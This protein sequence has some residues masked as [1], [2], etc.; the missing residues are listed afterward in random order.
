MNAYDVLN[1]SEDLSK[2]TDEKLG[3]QLDCIIKSR[4]ESVIFEELQ[5]LY[6]I[7][8][9]N[10]EIYVRLEAFQ[11]EFHNV[12]KYL[13]AYDCI[14]NQENRLEYNKKNKPTIEK[15][16]SKF[17]AK[18]DNV[19][20]IKRNGK[21][22]SPFQ[23]LGVDNNSK[24][25]I[26]DQNNYINTRTCSMLKLI[27]SNV[28][29]QDIDNLEDIILKISGHLW[30]YNKISTQE[31]R[32]EYK[33]KEI[34]SKGKKKIC[35]ASDVQIRR[36]KD[37]KKIIIESESGD[38]DIC[39]DLAVINVEPPFSLSECV[40]KGYLITK[41]NNGM[42]ESERFI[43]NIDMQRMS[44]DLEYREIVL[45]ELLSRK[46]LELGKKHLKGYIGEIDENNEIKFNEIVLGM[47]LSYYDRQSKKNVEQKEKESVNPRETEAKSVVDDD[48]E[49]NR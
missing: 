47:M 2:N 28:K 16:I 36:F 25:L 40:A 46:S 9:E 27:L 13:M 31:K 45:N 35:Y 5:K 14:A 48:S 22:V 12:L 39:Q 4:A 18:F 19:S 26:E 32:D 43:S 11:K 29:I 24:K 21:D 49:Q 3:L 41:R 38:I 34:L 7:L 33:Y 10:E 44:L 37:P 8:V 42:E 15:Y 23:M 6:Q 20:R 1:L 17:R 30:A